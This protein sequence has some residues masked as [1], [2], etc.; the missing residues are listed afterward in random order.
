MLQQTAGSHLDSRV[1]LQ[2]FRETRRRFSG[3]SVLIPSTSNIELFLFIHIVAQQ[4]VRP[5]STARRQFWDENTP[6]HAGLG[7]NRVAIDSALSVGKVEQG[8][9]HRVQWAHYN[10]SG[11]T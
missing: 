3:L 2:L 10:T 9:H 5:D 8:A 7:Y 1:K 4:T 6:A 11:K